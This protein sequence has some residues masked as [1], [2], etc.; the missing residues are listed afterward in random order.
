M[1]IGF[2]S[3][4]IGTIAF[5]LLSLLLGT[6]WRGRVHGKLLGIASVTTTIWA[7]ILALYAWFDKSPSSFIWT[8]EIVR[9]TV[10][11]IFFSVLLNSAV[12]VT[13][14]QGGQFGKFKYYIYSVSFGLLLIVWGAPLIERYF[15]GKFDPSYQLVGHVILALIGMV[16]I[17]QL[18]RNTREDQRWAIKFICLAVGGMF[19]YDFY[20]YSDA[21]LFRQI[22]TDIWVARGAITALMVPLI[23]IAAARNRNWVVDVFISRGVVFYSASLLGAGVYLL[24]MAI[25]GYY[26]KLY[27]GEWGTVVQ[28]IFI[29]GAFLLLSLL[30]FSGQLRSKIRVFLSK[31]FFS[32]AYDYRE[33]WLNI[34]STLSESKARYPLEQRAILALAELVE[35]PGGVLWVRD[36][37]S[38]AYFRRASFGD[39]SNAPNRIDGEDLLISKIK[40]MGW[41]VNLEELDDAPH[42]YADLSKPDWLV[43]LTQAWVIVP[44]FQGERLYGLVLLI[45]PRANIK[46]DWEVIELL[47]TAGIQAAS[48]LALE[49]AAAELYEA[50]QFEGFNRLSAF[51]IHDLKNIIA[52]LS[53]VARNAEKHQDNPEFMKDAIKTVDHSVE[54][55]SRLMSQLEKC[56]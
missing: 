30:F 48:Y 33:E 20:L 43:D 11:L 26:I 44:L 37:S 19:A 14:A 52:Q 47:K 21:L 25:S 38:G 27:G 49:D 2:Y 55:M 13:S 29:V 16:L 56:G 42:L 1:I 39:A 35:S 10:W 45:Q 46:W 32:Y 36:S 34:I 53:L 23:T 24:L 40:T 6:G 18:Y 5:L 12:K 51:V 7:A 4:L 50:K 31:N 17:E 8:I 3:Y 9:T 15:P 28:I 41:V 54:K 22:N